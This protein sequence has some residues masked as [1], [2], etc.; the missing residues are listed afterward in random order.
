MCELFEATRL[1]VQRAERHINDIHHQITAY[2]ARHPIAILVEKWSGPR[3]PTSPDIV[4]RIRVR[5]TVPKSVAPII[6]DA[7]HN[8]RA[9]LD[10]LAC[11]LVRLNDGNDAK[12]YFPFSDDEEQFPRM[13]KKR[14]MHRAAPQVIAHLYSLRPYTGGNKALRALHDLDIIDKHRALIPAIGMVDAAAGSISLFGPGG[15]QY[16][17]YTPVVDGQM[18]MLIRGETDLNSGQQLP[19]NFHLLLPFDVPMGGGEVIP[20]LHSLVQ[21]V[22]GIVESFEALGLAQLSSSRRTE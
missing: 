5:E 13:L 14:N 11:E 17:T 12:V 1:K 16:P 6:G 18:V 21:L 20:T 8:L 3:T 2:L 19:A 7:I 22:T 10:L 4:A 15:V 9:A